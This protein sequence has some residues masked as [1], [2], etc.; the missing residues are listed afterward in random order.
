MSA[1]GWPLLVTLLLWWGSTG[2]I[3]YL[4]TRPALRTVAMWGASALGV[5]ALFGVIASKDSAGAASAYCAFACGL[6]IWGW[7]E[8]SY[9]SGWITGPRRAQ[10]PCPPDVSAGRRFVLGIGTSLW[11][12]LLI[13]GI[14]VLLLLITRDAVNAVAA[15]TFAILW[16]MRWSAKLNLFLGVPNL[17]AE[18]FPPHLRYLESYVTR[19]SMNLLFP[20]SVTA[21]TFASALLISHAF[22]TSSEFGA[23]AGLTLG[24]L[25]GLAVLEHWFMVVPLRDAELW[26]WA[27]PRQSAAPDGNG[28]APVAARERAPAESRQLAAASNELTARVSMLP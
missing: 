18:F 2:V 23:V 6:L 4:V 5:A 12:E 9:L 11:H 20:V 1:P 27:L 8:M 28:Q 17:N 14:G 25:M 10:V 21:G 19:R 24:T 7:V 15:W 22:T 13:I 16:V 3:L 26:R